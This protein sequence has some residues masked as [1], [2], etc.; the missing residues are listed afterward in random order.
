[1]KIDSDKL[2]KWIRA[3]CGY[4]FYAGNPIV[5]RDALLDKIKELEKESEK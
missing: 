1:M 4:S 5:N 3:N 2:K